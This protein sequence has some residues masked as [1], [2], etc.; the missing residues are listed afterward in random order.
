MKFINRSS[1]KPGF[2]AYKIACKQDKDY[3]DNPDFKIGFLRAESYDAEKAA[4]RLLRHFGEK[5]EL[6]GREKLT[7]DIYWEDLGDDGRSYLELGGLQL[8]PRRD[9]DGRLVVFFGEVMKGGKIEGMLHG[10]VS[11]TCIVR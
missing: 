3:V 8:L 11:C 2:V 7:R 5:L 9:R 1:S 4:H 6:F 10:I